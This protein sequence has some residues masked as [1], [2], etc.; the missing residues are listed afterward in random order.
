[1]CERVMGR[2]RHIIM[3]EGKSLITFGVEKD[4]TQKAKREERGRRLSG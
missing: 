4:D 1:M 3:K 2:K